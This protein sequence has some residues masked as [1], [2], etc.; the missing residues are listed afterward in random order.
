MSGHRNVW[1]SPFHPAF[2]D[3]E[4]GACEAPFDSEGLGRGGGRQR[5]AGLSPFWST[6]DRPWI[7]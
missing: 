3:R 2:V 5:A 4:M 7:M 6:G 1:G